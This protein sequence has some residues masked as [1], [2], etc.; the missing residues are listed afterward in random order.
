MEDGRMKRTWA[1]LFVVGVVLISAVCGVILVWQAKAHHV[2]LFYL[3]GPLCLAIGIGS[4][5][6]H[7]SISDEYLRRHMG[8]DENAVRVREMWRGGWVGMPIGV[9][10]VAAQY[11]LGSYVPLP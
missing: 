1:V 10:L 4:L 7:L 8:S 2:P 6:L 5:V 9:A 3:L 11:F